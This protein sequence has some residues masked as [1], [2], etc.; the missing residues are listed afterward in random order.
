MEVPYAN[1][2]RGF[3]ANL[4]QRQDIVDNPAIRKLLQVSGNTPPLHVWCVREKSNH[5][6]GQD[7]SMK[8]NYEITLESLFNAPVQQLKY[9]KMLYGVSMQYAGNMIPRS[10]PKKCK[11]TFRER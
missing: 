1:F 6:D 3:I 8:A 2:S 9:Y 4:N 11:A 10:N 7:L 5:Q